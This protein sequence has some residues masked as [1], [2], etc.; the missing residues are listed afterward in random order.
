MAMDR[1]CSQ[2]N[3]SIANAGEPR[4]IRTTNSEQGYLKYAALREQF[5]LSPYVKL[6]RFDLGHSAY[7]ISSGFDL[8]D[9]PSK[10]ETID[11]NAGLLTAF[12]SEIAPKPSASPLEIRNVIELADMNSDANYSGHDPLS[13]ASLFPTLTIYTANDLYPTE[14]EKIFFLICLHDRRCTDQ[15]ID[16]Q[17]AK[18]LEVLAEVS[19]V[20]I[21]YRLLCQAVLDMNPSGLFLA[22]YR[23]LE[24]LYAWSKTKDLLTKINISMPWIELAQ[25]LE[26]TIGWYPREEQSL[27]ALMDLAL[28][29]DLRGLA[30][31][32]G[33]P[34]TD[35]SNLMDV[36]AKRVYRLRNSLVHYR[37]VHTVNTALPVEWN[38]VCEKLLHVVLHVYW[39]VDGAQGP[40]LWR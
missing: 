13:I 37:S 1:Y 33:E 5:Q 12:L 18:T 30:D 28:P 10:L 19:P 34:V 15:W 27:A 22:L 26:N 32:L 8:I 14:T 16:E 9:M 31:I 17:L 11:L 38:R 3:E 36:A 4:W 39:V 35:N 29:D 40:S 23:C 20:T 2:R 24:S 21:P 7:F 25:T 6:A